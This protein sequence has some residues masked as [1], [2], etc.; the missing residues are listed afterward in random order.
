MGEGTGL[1]QARRF[2]REHERG[3][4][5]A[6]LLAIMI[7]LGLAFGWG[8][9]RRGAERVVDAWE[10]RW[11]A[12]ID[13][14]ALRLAAC[15]TAIAA[16]SNDEQRDLAKQRLE[17]ELAQVEALDARFPAQA[18]VH[19]LDK[20]RERLLELL[21]NSYAAA[22]KKGK[23]LAACERLVQF[24][25]RNWNNHWI[26]AQIAADFGEGGTAQTALDALLAIHPTHLAAVEARIEMAFAGGKFA[27][28]P[29]LWRAYVEAYRLAP[30]DFS[31]GPT[32]LRLE[33]PS[34]GLPQR[35][36]V[37]FALPEHLRAQACFA[38][39]GWSI[40]VREIA[41]LPA[42]HAGVA[43]AA[44]MFR[45]PRGA[46]NAE[47]GAQVEAGYLRA[48]NVDSAL[49]RELSGPD[50]GAVRAAFELVAY[51]ACSQSLWNM[52]ETSYRNLLLWDELELMRARTRVGGCPQAGT[53]FDD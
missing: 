32:T 5:V 34:N 47:G 46:W 21:A 25:P 29:P 48:A 16:A 53:L 28:I 3:L 39:H 40:D 4:I 20:E 1:D 2:V 52:V 27:Q 22:D 7:V 19:R 51:K 13:T 49:R 6:W 44:S 12:A 17:L 31:F 10:A 26:Q 50:D 35:F 23:A 14:A 11:P 45:V 9:W 38:T 37:A 43:R 36:Q 15:R 30:V 24:D 18:S 33:I 41:F 8:L 42:Q